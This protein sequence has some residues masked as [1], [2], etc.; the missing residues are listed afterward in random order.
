MMRFS[1]PFGALF[2]CTL[3]TGP[4]TP[5]YW[6]VSP[7]V[8]LKHVWGWKRLQAC[9]SG[10]VYGLG[11]ITAQTYEGRALEDLDAARA[12]RSALCGFI[13]YGP[14]SHFYYYSL[15]HWML[16]DPVSPQCLSLSLPPIPFLNLKLK[17]GVC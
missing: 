9:I 8:S 4:V 12:L 15:D 2:S 13:A 6:M 17:R 16:F 10:V 5:C 3:A 1:L 14:L 7:V 11:D